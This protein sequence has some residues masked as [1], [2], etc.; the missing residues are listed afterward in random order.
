VGGACPGLYL[1][2][3]SKPKINL[4]FLFYFFENPGQGFLGGEKNSHKKIP[5]F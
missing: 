1:D 5:L 3:R 4:N 2:E